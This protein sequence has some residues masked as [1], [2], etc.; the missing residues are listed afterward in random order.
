MYGCTLAAELIKMGKASVEYK[1]TCAE[2]SRF[3]WEANLVYLGK[4]LQGK[5]RQ[6]E[7]YFAE[8]CRIAMIAPGPL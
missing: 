5:D 4:Y 2:K 7:E 1:T 3:P 8:N 6:N